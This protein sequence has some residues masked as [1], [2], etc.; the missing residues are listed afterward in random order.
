MLKRLRDRRRGDLALVS[1]TLREG[2]FVSSA[3]VAKAATATIPIVFMN[4][5]SN[6][7]VTVIARGFARGTPLRHGSPH[8]DCHFW[9]RPP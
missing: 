6:G 5:I 3:Q 1:I 7:T 2:R 4:G 8:F 9:R